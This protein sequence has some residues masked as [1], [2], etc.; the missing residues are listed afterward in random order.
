[1]NKIFYTF[2]VCILSI[3]QVD[4]QLLPVRNEY[5]W[6]YSDTKGKLTIDFQ[7]HD[8]NFFAE[9]MGR[10]RQNGLYGFIDE[11]GN[12]LIKNIYINASDFS[13]GLAL[14]TDTNQTQFFINTKGET[15]IEMPEGIS[16]AEPFVNGFSKISKLYFQKRNNIEE[17]RYHMGFMDK[18]GKIVIDPIYDDV[19]NFDSSGIARVIVGGKMGLINNL[20]KTI[21]QPTYLYI[22]PLNNN[23]AI[24]QKGLFYGYINSN[25]KII[26]KPRFDNAGDFGSGLAPVMIDSLWG[27]INT[28]GKIVIKPKYDFAETFSEDM[29]GVVLNRKWG[30]INTK[31]DLIIRNIFQD[32]APFSNGLAAV[33]LKDQWGYIDKTGNLVVM[34]QYNIVGSFI[35][36][37]SLVESDD[38]AIYINTNGTPAGG[39]KYGYDLIWVLLMSN[40]M[41]LLLQSFAARLGLVTGL[42]LAQASRKYYPKWA[43]MGLYILAEIA[44]AACDLAE[45]VGMAIGLNLLFGFPLLW[46]VLITLLDTF[47]LLFLLK[48]GMR[49]MEAF[50]IA[51]ICI[52]GISFIIEMAI[53]KPVWGDV[54]LGFK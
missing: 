52:I 42:D 43:N 33:K 8:A 26:V 5:L 38:N 18:S 37:I 46:G 41:A 24:V 2:I 51:L 45:V 9:N 28:A 6:G 49:M 54:I 13:E 34:P 7:F 1:M 4:A 50:I 44:I 48:K 10:V 39:S 25:G 14:V 22:G 47:L 29:A 53:V 35:N 30:M 15:S 11:N 3:I 27:Y 23:L 31:G 12:W 20:G 40:L 19:S 21:V 16:L 36:N 32:Y 17:P